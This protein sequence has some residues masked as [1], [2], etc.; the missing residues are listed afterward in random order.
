MLK[1]SRIGIVLGSLFFVVFFSYLVKT[2]VSAAGIFA[3]SYPAVYAQCASVVDATQ[4]DCEALLDIYYGTRGTG[5]VAASK[6][7]WAFS[8]DA[9]PTTIGDWANIITSG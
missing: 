5:W 3:P 8:G 6:L 4:S 1:N 7:R 2:N 9:T